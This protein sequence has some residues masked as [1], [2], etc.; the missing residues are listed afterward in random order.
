MRKTLNHQNTFSK[1]GEES[2]EEALYEEQL[3]ELGVAEKEAHNKETKIYLF[4]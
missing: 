2:T 3:R 4:N 1:A